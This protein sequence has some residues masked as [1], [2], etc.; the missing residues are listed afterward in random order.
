MQ[1]MLFMFFSLFSSQNVMALYDGEEFKDAKDRFEVETLPSEG[2]VHIKILYYWEDCIAS[3]GDAHIESINVNYGDQ[4]ICMINYVSSGKYKFSQVLRDSDGLLYLAAK[5]Q[6]NGWYVYKGATGEDLEIDGKKKYIHL[7][8]YPSSLNGSPIKVSGVWDYYS[9]NH[10]LRPFQGYSRDVD[11]KSIQNPSSIKLD[12]FSIDLKAKNTYLH[13]T[14]S[15]QINPID[16]GDVSCYSLKSSSSTANSVGE[17]MYVNEDVNKQELYYK[18]RVDEI[19]DKSI[20]YTSYYGRYAVDDSSRAKFGGHL[21]ETSSLQSVKVPAFIYPNSKVAAVFNS[22]SKTVSISWETPVVSGVADEDYI[23]KGFVIKRKRANT[24]EDWTVVG[25]TK[26]AKDNTFVDS[27]FAKTTD[28]NA[29]YV[30]R[31]ES[32]YA[33]DQKY[34]GDNY[35]A[36]SNLVVVKTSHMDIYNLVADIDSVKETVQLKWNVSGANWAS[37]SRLTI[38]RKNLENKK[39][40]ELAVFSDSSQVVSKSEDG[41]LVGLYLD[42]AAVLCTD[43]VYTL[44]ID[45]SS[46]YGEFKPL[47]SDTI[48]IGRIGTLKEMKCSKGYFSDRTEISWTSSGVFDLFNVERKL[49]TESDSQYKQIGTMNFNTSQTVYQFYDMSAS[50]GLVYSYRVGGQDK[51]GRE[52]VFSNKLSDTGFRAPTGAFYGRVTYENGQSVDSVEVYLSSENAITAQSLLMNGGSIK[53]TIPQL[54]GSANLTFQAWVAFAGSANCK[55]KLGDCFIDLSKSGSVVLSDKQRKAEFKMKSMLES[56]NHMSAVFSENMLAFYWNGVL[57]GVDS[58]AT[59]VNNTSS[60]CVIGNGFIGNIDEVRVWKRELP[61]SEI[62]TD[63]TRYIVGNE[64]SLVGYYTFDFVANG[65]CFDMSHVDDTYNGNDGTMD[66]GVFASNSV[67]NETQLAHKAITNKDGKYEII[68]VPYKGNGTAYTLTPRKGTHQFTPTQEIRLISE[69]VSSHTVNFTDNSSFEVSGIVVYSGGTY[70]VEGV[71]FTIDGVPALSKTG[72]YI[73]T[74]A[75]GLFTINVPVGT[76][77]VKAVKDGHTFELDGRICNSDGSDKNYQDIISGLKLYDNTKVKYIGRV[78]GGTVQE[79][80]PVGFSL[81][82]NNL[83]DDMQVV[84]SSTK[85][86]YSLQ[87]EANVHSDTTAH[88]ILSGVL[89][90]NKSAA[91][92]TTV[93]DYNK[94]DITIHVNNQTGEF[95]AWVYPIEYNVNLSVYGHDGIMGDNS[96]LDLSPYMISKNETY[97]YKD[98]VFVNGKDTLN[99][100]QIKNYKDSV[101]YIQKQVFT[102]RYRAQM[103]VTQLTKQGRAVDYF[104]KKNH[105]VTTVLGDTTNVILYDDSLKQYTLGLPTFITFETYALKY[106]IF[107]EYPYYVDNKNNV[108]EKKT[109]RVAIEDAEV[110]FNNKLALTDSINKDASVYMF[111]VGEPDMT[112]AIGTIGATFTYGNSDNPTSVSWV[113]PLGNENGEAYVLGA[114]QTG[115]DFV[116]AGPDHF[117][118]VLRDPPGSNSYSYLEK[119]VSF[120]EETTYT[121][122][123]NNEGNENWTT[124]FGT[125]IQSFTGS[126]TGVLHGKSTVTLETANGYTVGVEH[127]ENYTGS[128]TKSTNVTTTTRFQTSDDPIYDGANGDVY[129][130][131]STNLSFGSSISMTVMKRSEYDEANEDAYEATIKL[132]DKYA[133]VKKKGVS[134]GSYFKT[135]FAYPQIHIE[136]VLIPNI[137]SLRNSLLVLPNEVGD[138]A[139]WKSKA[140]TDKIP[141]YLSKVGKDDETFGSEGSYV[142]IYPESATRVDT[143]AYL[144]Q[145]IANWN[146]ALSDNDSVKASASKLLQNYSFQAGANVEYSESYSTTISS[147]HGFEVTVG[148]QFAN[149]MKSKIFGNTVKFSLEEHVATSQGREW[150]DELEM[151]HAK[152]FVLQEDGDDDYLSVSVYYENEKRDETYSTNSDWTSIDYG[153]GSVDQNSLKE[154]DNFSMFI[155]KTQGGATGCPYEDAYKAVHW[156]GHESTVISAATMKLEEPSIDMPKKFI[157][158]VPSGEDAYLTVYMKNNSETGEDQW[159][160]LRIVDASNPYGAVPSIDGNSMSGFALEYLV[161]AGDVLEKTIAITKGSVLNYD[162]LGLVLA[163][164]CQADPT[165]FLDVIADTVYFSVHFIPSCS[166]VTIAKPTNNWTYNTNC[167]TDTI[168]GVEKHYM[169]I[170][171][172]GFDVNYTDFE[173]IELQYKP[174]SASD[175]EWITLG[176]YYKEDS[177]AQKAIANGLNAFVINPEDGGNIYYNFYMDNLPD[178]KYDL[179]AVT[180][181]NINN[182]LYEN[183]SEVVSGIKDMYNPRLF[184]APKPANG[185]LTIEDDIRID[186]NE[187]IAEGMLT[188]NNFEVTG[189]RNGAATSHDVAIALDGENDYMATEAT[190]NFADKDL[191]FECWVNFDSL[192]NATFFSH[193]DANN[194]IEMGMNEAGKVVVKV[195]NRQLVSDEPAAWEKSSWNHVALAYDKTRQNVTAY[196]NYVALLSGVKV[197]A[198]TGNGIIEV[199]RSVSTQSNYFNGKVD[200][201]RIWSDARSQS[202]IQANSAKQLSGNDLNLIAYYEMDEAKGTATEDKAR[203]ANLVMKGGSWALPQGRSA[204]FDGKSYVA[205]NSASAVIASD[206]DFT[207]EFWFNAAL[208]SK[209]QTIL[210]SGDGIEDGS[211]NTSDVFSVGFDSFGK[212]VFRNNGTGTEVKGDFADN[213]WH[214]FT[215]A[216][217]R[218]SGI[219]RI[220]MDGE[221]NTYFD[222]DKVGRIAS[223]KIYAG[224][225]VWHEDASV[226]Q[227]VDQFFTGKVDEVRLWKLYRQQSQIESFYNQKVNGNEM[228]LLLYYPFEHY[229][230]WQGIAEMQFTLEDKANENAGEAQT[231]GSVE[232]TNNIP[233]VKDKGAVASLLYDW[234][235]NDDALIITLREQDYRIEKTIV[236][237]TVNKVQ[238]VNGNYIV[239]P[240]TWSAYIDRNQLKWM[241]DAVKI[242]K[243]AKEPYSFEMPIVNNGGSVINYTLNNMPSWLSAN[244]ES[245]VINPLA[246]QTIEFEIDPS[247]AVG[248]YDEVV[249]LT[250]SNNVTEPLTLNVTVEGDTP[251]WRVDPSKYEY[252]M[253]VFAKIKVDG[254]FSNDEKDMLAAFYNGECVGVAN[255]SY[256]KTTDMWYAMLTVYSEVSSSHD[257]VYRIWDASKGLIS[258]AEP[259]E[260]VRFSD[261]KVCGT[262]NSPVVFSNGSVKY[263]NIYLEKGWNWVSFNLENS[264]MSDM[265]LYLENGNWGSYSVIKGLEAYSANYSTENEQWVNTGVELNNVNMYKIHSE[266]AQ[267]LSVSGTDIDLTSKEIP[268]N[269]FWNYLS[270]LPSYSMPLKSALSGYEAS[271][272][273]L[274]KSIDGFAIYYGNEWIGSLAMMEPNVGYMLKNVGGVV[275]TLKYPSASTSLRSAI[276]ANAKSS[277]YESNMN[278]IAYAPEKMEGDQLRVLVANAESEVAEVT[279]D[280][281]RALQFINVAANNGE[282]VRFTLER[283]G[284]TY[285][286]SNQFSFEKDGVYGTPK[287]P[288]VLNFNIDGEKESLTT[289]PNPVVDELGVSGTMSGEA[290]VLLEIFDV[291]GALVYS[292]RVSSSDKALDVHINMSGWASGSYLLKV[293]QDNDEKT[294]KVVKK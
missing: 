261:N 90:K 67:P 48:K 103:E 249:Y 268:I 15:R 260:S 265:N 285:V 187:T 99:G 64:Q 216:V 115:T 100:Y 230:Q 167:A 156:K 254:V 87:T 168:D 227:T 112:T 57:I 78:C 210:S 141:Y 10:W 8:F 245:G 157:E 288:V 117:L 218:S 263:Q 68:A 71:Q 72:E 25:R 155:F 264:D 197:D 7:Y 32:R 236:N 88:A 281:E 211:P 33:E 255:M 93:A 177:L 276:V 152:G 213:N 280:D 143:I 37:D 291:T 171:I 35:T 60:A 283:D 153:A 239:S 142:V 34:T 18:F 209:G 52:N 235:V 82:K 58:T 61:A 273:D 107:E 185:V 22:N 224:A 169:P 138:T 98:T 21:Y 196:V 278:V 151:S 282:V 270:Y 41:V 47:V 207:L 180:F 154:K 95:V 129:I 162:N 272:G 136:Q 202:T 9:L 131:Y 170:T 46:A 28:I 132:T 279:L 259:S 1:F 120:T 290:D 164:K 14:R 165:G 3:T 17:Y 70:P 183:P 253:V 242:T 251:D 121:G 116:T 11:W 97:E 30:Y 237:F 229:I 225:R 275:K 204:S 77:E 181:C 166:D 190:R 106:L 79:E 250:N 119:G 223:D 241:D 101:D 195:G 73:M 109:D 215:L 163:S 38:S 212:L 219:A 63:Y 56:Y 135:L 287:N 123:F 252:N 205:M 24:N 104:G 220:Y 26:Y 192:Q 85:P 5:W 134:V 83:A 292:E 172:S 128:N 140:E 6:N 84:L 19:S 137:E 206:M 27:S 42:D 113:N 62:K 222:A 158:N 198:Y 20:S 75:S 243:K 16:Y 231:I 94:N 160:D 256:D 110:K 125:Y 96:T 150:N 269:K 2:C 50:P 92:L 29:T 244:V 208:G 51:C 203:G 232:A 246:K 36:Q 182:E 80:F 130:G 176:Y 173:H 184:G 12:S 40:E 191:T 145:S 194:A 201:F 86:E 188:V 200:Q 66:A 233:P 147:S 133:L 193:G 144:N 127:S 284:V 221:L 294:L 179:R 159:F 31:I 89:A 234:V 175:N 228:G 186:F 111:T 76:H 266:E 39:T 105:I 189:I 271:E 277:Q 293:S 23:N 118:A 274:I 214:N 102:K 65:V 289:Y 174:V 148:G 217:N 149:D 161:P 69:S 240:I 44:T 81:S 4:I 226:E 267:V 54:N 59:T 13:G 286:A 248:S 91:A 122:S 114:H 262:P 238:D 126:A 257:I 45:A 199:G 49:A 53:T 146:K 74:D 178:Q 124:G 139:K 108:D 258:Q 247:L 55:I 43:Y